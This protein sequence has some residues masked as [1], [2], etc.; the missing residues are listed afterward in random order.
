MFAVERSWDFVFA[1]AL[2]FSENEKRGR[3]CD[4]RWVSRVERCSVVAETRN[5]PQS[6]GIP[7]TRCPGTDMVAAPGVGNL[8]VLDDNSSPGGSWQHRW[9]SLSL[10]STRKWSSLPFRPMQGEPDGYPSTA[11]MAKYLAEYEQNMKINVERPVNIISVET[12][13]DSDELLITSDTN[14]QWKS[15]AVVTCTGSIPPIVPRARYV[16]N[17]TDS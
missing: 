15:K 4:W 9:E 3:C 16:K 8:V 14:Q 11:E 10:F 13:T 7:A 5:H 12:L 1:F 2:H 17:R 6:A